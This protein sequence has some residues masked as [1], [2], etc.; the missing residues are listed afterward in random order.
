[1]KIHT[2]HEVVTLIFFRSFLSLVF[3]KQGKLIWNAFAWE[4]RGDQEKWRR[5][6]WISPHSVLFVRK[7]SNT[8][9][10]MAVKVF[11]LNTAK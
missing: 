3:A 4:N 8:L 5:W 6:H 9:I 1:M 11:I 10:I 7:V 2:S